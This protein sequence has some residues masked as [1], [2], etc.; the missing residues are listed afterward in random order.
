MKASKKLRERAAQLCDMC[1]ADRFGRHCP[2]F[3]LSHIDFGDED[4]KAADLATKVF[5][6]VPPTRYINGHYGLD[7]AEAAAWLRNNDEELWK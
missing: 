2:G 4:D 6:S 7:W 3:D 1:A 5:M